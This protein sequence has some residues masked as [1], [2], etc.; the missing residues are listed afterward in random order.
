MKNIIYHIDF[1]IFAISGQREIFV[2]IPNYPASSRITQHLRS[3]I[4]GEARPDSTPAQQI[5]KWQCPEITRKMQLAQKSIEALG[6]VEFRTILN[7]PETVNIARLAQPAAG[8]P[9]ASCGRCCPLM[10]HL[11]WSQL[12]SQQHSLEYSIYCNRSQCRFK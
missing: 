2:H 12:L 4:P 6:N 9:R 7:F 11:G 1:A 10:T 3:S 8:Q 5:L